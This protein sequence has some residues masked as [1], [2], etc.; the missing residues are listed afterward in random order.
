M[1]G[2]QVRYFK[3]FDGARIAYAITGSGLPVV[4]MPSW[5]THLEYQG[6]SVAWQPWLAALSSRY[7]TL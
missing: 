1:Q 7:D 4:L 5:L 2:Q 3:S 6:R